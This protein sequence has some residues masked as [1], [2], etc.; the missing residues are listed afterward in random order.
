MVFDRKIDLTSVI[1]HRISL[2]KA[3]EGFQLLMKGEASKII[4]SP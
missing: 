1:T 4:L 3:E 2:E